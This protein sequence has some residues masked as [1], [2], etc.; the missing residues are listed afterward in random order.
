M[1]PAALP[2]FPRV[3]RHTEGYVCAAPGYLRAQ[4]AELALD[5]QPQEPPKAAPCCMLLRA[6]AIGS[7]APWRVQ[8]EPLQSRIMLADGKQREDGRIYVGGGRCSNPTKPSGS[9]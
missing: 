8:R 4:K 7:M 6:C 9:I 1:V 2:W 3:P 5:V